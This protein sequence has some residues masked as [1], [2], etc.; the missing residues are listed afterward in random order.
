MKLL[1]CCTMSITL[2]ILLYF[3]LYVLHALTHPYI[4][5]LYNVSHNSHKKML[6]LHTMMIENKKKTYKHKKYVT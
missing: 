2:F 3:Y 1:A 4:P 5:V 6:K